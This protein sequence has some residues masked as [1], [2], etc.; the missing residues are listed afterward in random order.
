MLRTFLVCGLTFLL[1]AGM[2]SAAG[3]GKKPTHA[4][5]GVVDNVTRDAGRDTGAIVLTV[6]HKTK[7]SPTATPVER[8]VR[9]TSA[10]KFFFVR[11]K[12]GSVEETPATFADVKAGEKVVVVEH[13]GKSHQA[14]KVLI[15]KR[16][17]KT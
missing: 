7:G 10:T 5:R 12:K 2:A 1:S 3:K 15:H 14:D 11:G 16:K 13:A 17:K 8:K 4:L 6:K 9:V